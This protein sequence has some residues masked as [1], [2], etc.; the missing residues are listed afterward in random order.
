MSENPISSEQ[1]RSDQSMIKQG[2]IK[3][4][5]CWVKTVIVEN[6]FCPFAR[7]ELERGSIRYRVKPDTDIEASLEQALN[8]YPEPERIP[9]QN[10]ERA[11]ELGL[12]EMQ[13]QL[14]A[15]CSIDKR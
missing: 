7:R 10:I 4:T 15:C 14:E 1:A 13:R 9:E 5:R 12:E 3:Q 11:R 6:N 2:V 8:N